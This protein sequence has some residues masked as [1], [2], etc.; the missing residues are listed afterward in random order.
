[1]DWGKV[2]KILWFSCFTLPESEITST[3]E[4]IA[5]QELHQPLGTSPAPLVID[6]QEDEEYA[7]GH[8][9]EFRPA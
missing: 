6:V 9:P 8:L 2:V 3:I 7:A 5:P 1:M 4:Y